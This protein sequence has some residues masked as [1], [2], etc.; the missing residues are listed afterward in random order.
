LL[1]LGSLLG[2]SQETPETKKALFT[3]RLQ[4][5]EGSRTYNPA[6]ALATYQQQA[7]LGNPEAMN[8]LGLIYTKGIAATINEAEGIS[9]LEKAA[10]AGY[11]KAYYNLGVLYR[12]GVNATA[13]PKKAISF[14][15]K[16]ATAGYINAYPVWGRMVMNGI[17][18]PQNYPLAISIF[19]QGG[20]KGNG[21]CLYNLG[22]LYYKGFGCTQD[23]SLAIQQF[24]L[25]VQKNNP[26]AMYMLGLCYRNGYG[27]TI[28]LEK[29]KSYLAKSAAMG[30]KPSQMELDDSEAENAKPNQVKTVSA[31]IAEVIT[32]TETNAPDTF[33]KVKQNPITANISGD[34]S[35]YLLR[36]D[37]SGQNMISK[38]PLQINLNQD[39]KE[40]AGEWKETAG[41][42]VTFTAQIQDDAIVFQ[43]S[44]IDR[45]EHFYKGRL[46][47]YSF[48]EAKVQLLQTEESLFL[49]GNLQLYNIKERENEKPM[50]LI[51]EK[52]QAKTSEVPEVISSVII[53]PN[54]VVT[55]FNL[56][57]N[58]AKAV[59]VTM[60]IYYI[61]GRPL[62]TEQWNNLEQGTQTK[63]LALNA[64]AG[65]YLL[66]LTYGTEIKTTLLI[67]K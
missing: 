2:Y 10:E 61:T 25:A 42:T 14:F 55:D 24:E 51:L 19:K 23:Y 26:W 40:L 29:A 54:P 34:Y 52:K 58:L 36:Y 50:Y 60:S 39:G 12:E 31:P 15:E 6:A 66:R 16:A 49:V 37:F 38:T 11:A 8:A 20:E 65:Y 43:N 30:V 13:D 3:A 28:D 44:T 1:L 17:G 33:Q 46:A 5:M 56:S 57:F 62:Y 41:D 67:K 53:H 48:K 9:W 59:D 63:T 35:G 4:L 47:T 21:Q 27:V 64:P 22:Y 7:A 45:T 32:I 18:V